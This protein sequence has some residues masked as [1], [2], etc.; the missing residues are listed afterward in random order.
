MNASPAASSFQDVDPASRA[1]CFPDF[2]GPKI[3]ES[4][5]QMHGGLASR[6]AVLK[7]HVHSQGGAHLPAAGAAR[8]RARM[9][10]GQY[11]SRVQSARAIAPM[12]RTRQPTASPARA[13]A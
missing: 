10:R 8:R 2:S 3:A 9:A 12:A 1:P 6:E 4:W 7:L 11:P 5:R 13:P